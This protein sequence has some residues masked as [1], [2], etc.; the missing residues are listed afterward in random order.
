MLEAEIKELVEEKTKL[1]KDYKKLQI[2]VKNQEENF[3][4]SQVFLDIAY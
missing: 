2:Q 1:M 3:F 4:Q